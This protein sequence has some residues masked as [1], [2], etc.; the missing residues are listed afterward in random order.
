MSIASS[1]ESGSRSAAISP[2]ALR[3][4]WLLRFRCTHVS[5]KRRRSSFEASCCIIAFARRQ[6]FGVTRAPASAAQACCS[7]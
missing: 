1:K 4:S 5:R 7:E 6:L 3:R 2:S